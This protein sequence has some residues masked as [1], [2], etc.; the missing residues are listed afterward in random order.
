MAQPLT[1]KIFNHFLGNKSPVYLGN[2]LAIVK[3]IG[4]IKLLVD[5]RDLSIAPHI[6]ID[7][8]WEPIITKFFRRTVKKGFR[9]I[10]IGSNIGYFTTIAAK[11]VGPDGKVYAFEANPDVYKICKNNI[12]LN[13]LNNIVNIKNIAISDKKGTVKFQKFTRHQGNSTIVSADLLTE[14]SEEIESITVTTDAL[15][16]LL[17]SERIDF[18]K[19]DAEGSERLIFSGME[20]LLKNNNQVKILCEFFPERLIQAKVNPEEF[21]DYISSLGFLI[22][23]I[24]DESKTTRCFKDELLSKKVSELFLQKIH[25]L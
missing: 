24:N 8:Q 2:N 12:E 23:T 1:S 6:L 3:T 18:I 11:Q 25:G 10:E 7:R 13:G 14:Y 16:Q 22:L 17:P 20:A 21:I 9:V 5:T 4:R 19:I 15:D